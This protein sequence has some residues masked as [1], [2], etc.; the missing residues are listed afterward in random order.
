MT[1]RTYKIKGI[2]WEVGRSDKDKEKNHKRIMKTFL[3]LRKVGK[4]LFN[5]APSYLTRRECS[6]APTTQL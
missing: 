5:D 3:F 6:T 4:Q 1:V 2:Q